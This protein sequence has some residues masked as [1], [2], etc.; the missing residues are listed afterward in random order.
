M[1]ELTD[2]AN[3]KFLDAFLAQADNQ[4]LYQRVLFSPDDTKG[5]E[6]LNRRFKEFYA[7]ARLIKYISSIIHY[8]SIELSLRNRKIDKACQPTDEIERLV[9]GLTCISNEGDR[10]GIQ[11]WK[12]A[13]S[14]KRLLEA[15]Q[16]LTEKEQATLTLLYLRNLKERE[17]ARLLGVTQQAVSKVKKRALLKLRKQLEGGEMHE[18]VNAAIASAE[19]R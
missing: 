15:I 2:A 8:T 5:I 9:D 17:V 11:E 4:E 14:D 7:E 18:P 16:R 19:Q 10:E 1:I 12:D 6:E 3:K 13:L